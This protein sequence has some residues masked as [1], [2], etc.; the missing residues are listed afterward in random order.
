MT[1][2]CVM[3]KSD[4]HFTIELDAQ[5]VPEKIFWDATDNPN[6]GLGD[7]RAIAV[8][9]WDHYHRGTLKIDLWTKE[10]E[11]PDM[12]RFIIEIISGLGD[13]ALTATG[14]QKIARDIDALCAS[15]TKHVDDEIK[16]N[17]RKA[18]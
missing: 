13:T 3:K 4:I 11:V 6:E 5:Q 9:I 8:S 16:E 17:N 10:M 15:L 2:F 7:T 12:K 14:D 1:N 18:V